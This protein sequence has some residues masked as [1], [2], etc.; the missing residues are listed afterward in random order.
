MKIYQFCSKY[1][2][3]SIILSIF[4]TIYTSFYNAFVEEFCLDEFEHL[5]VSFNILNGLVPYRD[6]FEHHHGLL[7]Y[8]G[9][10]F[11]H[12]FFSQATVLYFARIIALMIFFSSF[13]QSIKFVVCFHWVFLVQY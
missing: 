10:I 2:K 5:Q 7:W 12:P 6:F 1:F 9:A 11:L 8:V 3:I 13:F 4:I